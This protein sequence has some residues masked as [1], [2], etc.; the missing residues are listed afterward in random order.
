MQPTPDS[1]FEEA[2]DTLTRDIH[3]AVQI[4]TAITGRSKGK[5]DSCKL[6]RRRQSKLKQL[7]TDVHP[8]YC[9][10]SSLK[11]TL[12][13]CVA[14]RRDAA[15]DVRADAVSDAA[16]C[17]AARFTDQFALKMYEPYLQYV[18]RI[19]N[20]VTVHVA[21]LPLLGVGHL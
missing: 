2:Y 12:D 4:E 16:V 5:Q 18:P 11:R 9:V 13:A 7:S 20:V 17:N 8:E 6:R 21:C 19:V 3:A 14:S 1:L 15:E 10:L